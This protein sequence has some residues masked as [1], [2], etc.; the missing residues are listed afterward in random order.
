MLAV[1]TVGFLAGLFFSP[2]D[3]AAAAAGLVPRLDGTQS[4]LLAV[5]MLGATVM[6]HAVYLHSALVRDRH[7]AADADCAGPVLKA[8][9]LDVISGHD[10]RRQRQHRHAAARRQHAVRATSTACQLPTQRIADHLGR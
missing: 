6:P 3:P 1:V 2:P 5:G 8:I 7:G 9:Q 10:D 4:A